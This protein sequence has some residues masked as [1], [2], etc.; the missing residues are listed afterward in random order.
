MKT[1][2]YF[3]LAVL[4]TKLLP[5]FKTCSLT[6]RQNTYFQVSPSFWAMIP[7]IEKGVDLG[8]KAEMRQYLHL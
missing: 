6:T 2:P 5:G 4:L 7:I 8:G 3:L 1:T